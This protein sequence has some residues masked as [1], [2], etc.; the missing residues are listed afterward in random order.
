MLAHRAAA[1]ATLA[2]PTTK[3]SILADAVSTIEQVAL[4]Y[5]AL[6]EDLASLADCLVTRSL[7][8]LEPET[9]IE[10]LLCFATREHAAA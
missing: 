6:F 10:I 8:S 7:P 1:C 9:A 3:R 5:F 4:P 2:D